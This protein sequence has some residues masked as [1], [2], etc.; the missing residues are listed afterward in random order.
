MAGAT[1][2][3]VL[4]LLHAYELDAGTAQAIEQLG[5]EAVTVLAEAALGA[6]PD[7]RPK[8]RQNAVYLLGV[9]QHP[10]AAE[11]VA[12]LVDEDDPAI[13]IR[14]LR[15]ARRQ[16]NEAVVGTLARMLTSPNLTPVVAAETVATLD[17][18]GSEAARTAIVGYAEATSSE[19]PHRGSRIV[20]QYLAEADATG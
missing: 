20:A 11:T 12:L 5:P 17:A 3:Q 2:Q 4:Q 6:Y 18:I 9:V 13:A 15:A 19:L 10:Q 14:A 16:R 1:E 8:A 7:L